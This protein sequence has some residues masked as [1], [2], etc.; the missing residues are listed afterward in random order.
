[1]RMCLIVLLLE[2]EFQEDIKYRFQR[3][4][5][6]PQDIDDVYDGHLYKKLFENNGSL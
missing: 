2:K 4:K 3:K 1:M 6:S 5:N